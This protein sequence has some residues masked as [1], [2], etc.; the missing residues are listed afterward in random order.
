MNHETAADPGGNNY[1]W[2]VMEGT[3]CFEPA[4]GCSLAGDILP[5]AQYSHTLGCSITGGYVYRGT[6][7]DL[8]GL[9]TCTATSAA[10]GCGP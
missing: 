1:G 4:T 2:D 5:V 7:R 6:H 8:Q 3:S 10:A 9:S